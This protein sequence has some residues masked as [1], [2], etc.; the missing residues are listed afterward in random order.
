MFHLYFFALQENVFGNFYCGIEQSSVQ[1]LLG[2]FEGLLHG[3]RRREV[4]AIDDSI[5]LIPGEGP[6][7]IIVPERV[8]HPKVGIR[9]TL[10]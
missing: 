5:D 3:P 6:I 4:R 7:N 2:R 8:P 9:L 10:P 1:L